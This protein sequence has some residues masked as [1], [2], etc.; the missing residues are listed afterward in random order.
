MAEKHSR[1]RNPFSSKN[2]KRRNRESHRRNALLHFEPLEDRTL[3]TAVTVDFDALDTSSG[4]VSGA[5]LDAYLA[6]FGIAI[7]D[8]TGTPAPPDPIRAN[9]DANS[10]VPTRSTNVVASSSPNLFEMSETDHSNS[11]TFVFNT[12]L[13]SF[14]FTRAGRCTS[15]AFPDWT[16]VAKDEFGTTLDSVG[17]PDGGTSASCSSPTP[18]VEFTLDG[19]GIKSVTIAS[20]SDGFSGRAGPALDD[21]VLTV[22]SANSPP[23]VDNPIADVEANEDADDTVVDL[24]NTFADVDA[25]DTLTLTVSNNTNG[26][27]VSA[28]IVGTSLT[29]DYL[30][31]Q[32]GTADITI[33]ATDGG[34]LFAEYTFNITVISSQQQLQNLIDDVGDLGLNGGN[35]NA[36]TSKLNNAINKLNQGKTNAGV[37]QI[38]AFINQ[39]NAFV[40]SGKLTQAQAD[41]LIDAAN[42]AIA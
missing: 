37:N 6:G 26:S 12:S 24:T 39:V 20:G 4:P 9:A 29:L 35:T 22:V 31:D 15:L 23:V 25:G 42:A 38:Q 17:E 14:A 1:F 32:N 2:R 33:R 13:I 19:P 3:L 18:P 8:V 7:T 40:N 10:G 41:D 28:S 30:P 36:L 21:L 11:Y 16:A 34:G 27:L 5:A